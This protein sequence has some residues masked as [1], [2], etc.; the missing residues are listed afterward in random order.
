MKL[1]V[2]PL[3]IL[4][5]VAGCAEGTATYPSASPP[6]IGPDCHGST[7]D[8]KSGVCIGPR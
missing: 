8:P 7:W 6:T 4:A 5:A 1:L 2:T 3:L